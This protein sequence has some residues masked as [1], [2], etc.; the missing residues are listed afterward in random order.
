MSE[1]KPDRNV[2]GHNLPDGQGAVQPGIRDIETGAPQHTKSRGRKRK[3]KT[4]HA[5]DEH[6]ELAETP[7]PPRHAPLSDEVPS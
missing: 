2:Y 4:V 6:P 5:L 3:G 1:D 7:M